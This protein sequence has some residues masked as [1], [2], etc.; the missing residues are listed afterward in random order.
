[1]KHN[2]KTYL[3]MSNRKIHLLT[4]F[5]FLIIGMVTHLPAQKNS[6]ICSPNF[7]AGPLSNCL[8]GN[9]FIED[10]PQQTTC[11]G[12]TVLITPKV[13]PA[14]G[15]YFWST[16]DSTPT[17]SLP[18]GNHQLV[19]T[20]GP[21][22]T[23]TID[24]IIETGSASIS[25]I[26]FDDLNGNSFHD[27]SE[28]GWPNIHII[29]ENEAGEPLDTVVSDT[30]GYYIFNCLDSGF[31]HTFIP[32]LP[33]GHTISPQIVNSDYHP[34]SRKVT[35]HNTWAS[36]AISS[37]DCGLLSQN[38]GTV[39]GRAWTDKD[40][41]GRIDPTEEG[42]EGIEIFIQERSI[43]WP[44]NT[45]YTDEDGYYSF[46]YLPSGVPYKVGIRQPLPEGTKGFSP[47]WFGPDLTSDSHV[48][49]L[50]GLSDPF[51]VNPFSPPQVNAG[52]VP[53]YAFLIVLYLIL[54]GA[55]DTGGVMKTDLY[56]NGFLP[57]IEPF[58]SAGYVVTE[59]PLD[60]INTFAFDPVTDYVLVQIRKPIGPPASDT[61]QVVASRTA[62]VQK[63]GKVVDMQNGGPLRFE[64]LPDDDYY[65]GV[66]H[67]NHLDAMTL[68][69]VFLDGNKPVIFDFI[70]P[71]T[72]IKGYQPLDELDD[73][74]M[75]LI[76][77]DCDGNG[78][79]NPSDY[80]LHLVPHTGL[81]GYR[82]SDVN[83]NGQ[84]QP[85]DKNIHTV[86]NIGK[87]SGVK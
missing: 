5:S 62:V 32:I 60:S 37:I 75:A 14:G 26:I 47:D 73:G 86:P 3:E 41:D 71:N 57:H 24:I 4:I 82:P 20:T 23:D 63:D 18:V 84:T 7:Q 53:D 2:S 13:Y 85:S 81:S 27:F 12:Q 55:M 15:T 65:L 74:R 6:C 16:G 36:N 61:T 70:N 87:S 21:N 64:G 22:C 29:L 19:Y 58:S 49:P 54:K 78:I 42:L 8:G 34:F 1:M 31:Y 45:T 51:F 17:A 68:K 28:G 67:I 59:N 38:P 46:H 40:N 43:G 83:R 50:T 48:N 76:P 35:F 10:I 69:P 79:I 77:G 56:D 39:T 72:P 52:I 80:I 25:G 11:S 9:V 33:P 66:V 44:Y 30:T